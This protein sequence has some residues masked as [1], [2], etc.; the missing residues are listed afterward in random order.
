MALLDLYHH[1][2]Y[3]RFI[4]YCRLLLI[5]TA[6]CSC[7]LDF[8]RQ[9]HLLTNVITSKELVEPSC[10]IMAADP[11]LKVTGAVHEL[12]LCDTNYLVWSP[13]LYSKTLISTFQD[14]L[15]SAEKV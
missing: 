3:F 1:S 7:L 13:N 12:L 15:S 4:L 14:K 2:V 10:R 11:Q 6:D 8:S 5:N 9:T